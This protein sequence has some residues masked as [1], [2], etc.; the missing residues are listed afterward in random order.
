MRQ[1]I[2]RVTITGADDSVDPNELA[3][4][5]K[6][7]PFVEWGIL[8][9]ARA[10]GT[11]RFPSRKWID[12]L[13]DLWWEMLGDAERRNAAGNINN[14]VLT[15][16]GHVCG[17][18]VREICG[19]MWTVADSLGK[20]FD[21]FSRIQLNFHAEVHKL[22]RKKFIEGFDDERLYFRQFIF[23]L[24]DVNN[25]ILDMAR[26]ADIDAVALF[27]TS[28]GIGRL[29]EKWPAARD[30]YCGYAGGLSPENLTIQLEAIEKVCGQGPIW[31]DVETHVRSDNDS[32]FDLDKVT[33]FLETAEP[34]VTQGALV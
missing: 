27:D 21:M 1:M 25:D 14:D 4:L 24:D 7:F 10:E 29:P 15:L 5:S 18:W 20:S 26:E 13:S 31:I 28:G 33:K 16:S 8:L 30:F 22:D 12:R 3:A 19:G 32:Q 9:S 34:W 17:R 11:N 23:Q 2:D 6:R